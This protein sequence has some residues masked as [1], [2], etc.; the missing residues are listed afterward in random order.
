MPPLDHA[1]RRSHEVGGRR[2]LSAPRLR[3]GTPEQAGLDPVELGHLAGEVH[4]LTAGAR[5]WAPGAVLLAGRG[6]VIAVAEAAGWAVRYAAYDPKT[7]TGVELPPAD[8]IPATL[9]T[10][11]DLAS[12]TKL[13]TTV[14]AMQQVER[15]TLS[16]DT[17]IGSHLPDFHI[18]AHDVTVRQLL[19][20]TSG[21]RPELPLYDCPDDAAR[22]DMLRA[23][24]PTGEPGTYRY[25]DLNMLLLQFVLERITRRTLD[26]LVQDGITRP[27]GMT[28]TTFGPCPG[29]AATEDQRRPWAKAD[30]GMLRGVVH[31]ENAWALGGVAGHAGLFSTARDLAV[32]CRTL[33]AGGS[34][35]PARILGPDFVEPM[36]TPPG[37][38]FAVDQRWFMGELAGRGAAGHTGFTGTSLVVD[39]ATD[40]FLI[41]L[42]NTVHPRRRPPDS[43]PRA[44]LATRLARAVQGV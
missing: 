24:A 17:R 32:F 1:R 36:L 40:T 16:M 4:A 19:T 22:L 37:L 29:A 12:L 27:L 7:G 10:P 30:R 21:L 42:A 33:L 2:E 44:A 43:G 20:H 18:A 35:G 38:G 5:P 26:V 39:R 23:E 41:L 6:P 11:F 13:F 28:T 9:D 31:D 3:V 8:R 14:V 34:Y 15:G 25:S